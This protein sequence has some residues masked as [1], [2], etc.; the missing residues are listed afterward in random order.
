[1]KT[2]IGSALKD[3]DK[4]PRFARQDPNPGIPFENDAVMFDWI[5]AAIIGAAIAVPFLL[6]VLL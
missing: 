2:I 4:V 1:M 6:L 3:A 5:S